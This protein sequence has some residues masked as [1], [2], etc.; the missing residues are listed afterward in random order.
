MDV[1]PAWDK[2]CGSRYGRDCTAVSKEVGKQLASE[3]C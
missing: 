2:G 1:F 3:G